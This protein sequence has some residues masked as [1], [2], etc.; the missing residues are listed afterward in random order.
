MGYP[1][2]LPHDPIEQVGIDLFLVRGSVRLNALM[3]ITRNMVVVR[4][5]G[6]LTLVDPLRLRAEEEERL[7]DLGAI[8]RVMRLGPFHGM[9]D[10]YYV[11]TFRAQ[12]WAPGPSEQHPEPRPDVVFDEATALPIPDARVLRFRGTKQP[13][14]VLHLARDAGVLVTCDAIQHYGDYRWCNFAARTVMPWIGFPR[15]TV[16]GPFWLKLMTPPGT[17]LRAEFD[18]L[19]ATFDFEG[20][21]SAHGS[22]LASGAKASVAAAVARAKFEV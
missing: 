13:E 3:T 12:F 15:T 1:D 10:R 8:R 4:S 22:L 11:D 19:L 21:V 20:L 5:G 16:V 7:R 9:D 18:R 14:A 17:S 6:E 2:P